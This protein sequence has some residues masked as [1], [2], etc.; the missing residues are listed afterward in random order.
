MAPFYGGF[1]G[2]ALLLAASATARA[3]AMR[4][5]SPFYYG[6][7]DPFW[8]G[9]RRRSDSYTVYVSHLDLDIRRKV[10]NAALFEGHAKARSRTDD[11]DMTRAEPGRSDVHRLPGHTGETIKITVPPAKK[12]S[13]EPKAR[14][15]TVGRV[16]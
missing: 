16:L 6:W 8:Y 13:R 5:R 7:D 15:E 12:S 11:L 3:L 1:Y 14:P 2:A 10:D 4:L 9:W